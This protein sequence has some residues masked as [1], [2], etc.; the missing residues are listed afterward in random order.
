[1]REYNIS[2]KHPNKRYQIKQEDRKERVFEYIKNVWTVRKF[3]IDNFS[4]D[5]P[6]ING[7]QMPLHR[8]ESASQK[9][10][11]IKGCEAFVKENYS[12]SRERITAFTQ[13][14]SD[15]NIV[16][17]PEFVFK[18]KGTRTCLK[19]PDGIKYHW[20]PKGSYR[21]EQMLATIAN[22]PNR[23]HIFTMNKYCIYVLD[24]YSV[25]IMPEVKA[26]LLKKGYVYIGIGGGITGD[27]QINDTDI[28]APLKKKYRELEQELMICQLRADPK[29]IPQPSRDDMMKMLVE[30]VQSIDVD[31]PARYKALWLTSALDGSED[32]LVS[33]RIMSLVGEELKAFRTELM[34]TASVK[35]LKD[36]LKLITPPKGVSRRNQALQSDS[37]NAPID[38]GEELIDCEG[39]E[40]QVNGQNQEFDDISDDEPGGDE[41]PVPPTQHR[42][43]EQP[44][45]SQNTFV[46]LAPLCINEELRKD[47]KFVDELGL[48]LQKGETSTRFLSQL[49]SIKK[50]YIAARRGIKKRIEAEHN[51]SSNLDVSSNEIEAEASEVDDELSFERNAFVL[52]D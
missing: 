19:P 47:A 1:M 3:F 18:G 2:L 16:V 36:L 42:I 14:S 15:P 11:N 24:D 49:I 50:Q 33:E 4:V 51:E 27:I 48:L 43:A 35:Q 23:H 38:E 9:T 8:N 17:K 41:P 20:A 40:M 28:H 34:Q 30:S 52:F 31:I 44:S 12:L 21:L 29:K 10:L 6:I 39:D 25:H 37:T 7:D 22:L 45:C 26:A 46:E 5:P 32:Y 13:V